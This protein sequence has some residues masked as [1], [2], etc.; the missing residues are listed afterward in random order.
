MPVDKVV[1]HKDGVRE[2]SRALVAREAVF[3]DRELEL[4]ELASPNSTSLAT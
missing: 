3:C 1:L 2:S 4:G